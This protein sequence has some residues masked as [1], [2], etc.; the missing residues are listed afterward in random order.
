[1]HP[2]RWDAF[3]F[4]FHCAVRFCFCP[5]E[6]D[7]TRSSKFTQTFLRLKF[8]PILFTGIFEHRLYSILFRILTILKDAPVRRAAI[9]LPLFLKLYSVWKYAN[10]KHNPST[11]IH[12]FQGIFR[13]VMVPTYI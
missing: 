8:P 12:H 5:S 10:L 13:I 2:E 3:S 6:V 4:W 1:M 11:S 7:S 9:P